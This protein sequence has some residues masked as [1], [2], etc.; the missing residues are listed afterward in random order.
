[1]SSIVHNSYLG[2]QRGYPKFCL[3]LWNMYERVMQDLPRSNNSVEGWHHAFN[4]RVSTRHPSTV[5]LTK[6]ILRA[7]SRFEVDIERLHAGA[8]PEKEE[9]SV[10]RS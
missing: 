9:K 6:C 7:Q 5:K 8:L 3:Q 4:N 2:V 1:M 10:Y